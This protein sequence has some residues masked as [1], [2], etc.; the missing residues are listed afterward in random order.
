MTKLMGLTPLLLALL[1]ASGCGMSDGGSVFSDTC[2]DYCARVG[3]CTLTQFADKQ[4]VD[5]C[6]RVFD[7]V[8][9][10]EREKDQQI[11][12]DANTAAFVCAGTELTCDEL[13][14]YLVT[15][16][17]EKAFVR[18]RDEGKFICNK[19]FPFEL[20]CCENEIVDVVLACPESFQYAK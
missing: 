2:E 10:T 1:L 3:V 6:L 15:A 4:C 7:R 18:L 9:E 13:K 5:R 12:T 11:C 20:D 19:A 17:R 14:E 8:V 16:L